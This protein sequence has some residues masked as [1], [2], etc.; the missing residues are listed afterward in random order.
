M[1]F[2]RFQSRPQWRSWTTSTRHPSKVTIW[3][4][5]KVKPS[6]LN[7]GIIKSLG[8]SKPWASKPWASK[9]SKRVFLWLSITVARIWLRNTAIQ[10]A[11]WMVWSSTMRKKVRNVSQSSKVLSLLLLDMVTS[12]F[13]PQTQTKLDSQWTTHQIPKTTKWCW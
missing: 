4:M 12:S 13:Q 7:T 10:R 9:P 3:F 2:S 6:L 5:K 8:Y 11:R 1:T